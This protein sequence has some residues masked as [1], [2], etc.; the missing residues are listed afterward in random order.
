MSDAGGFSAGAGVPKEEEFSEVAAGSTR[1]E[2]ASGD[3]CGP[4]LSLPYLPPIPLPLF[5]L[6]S[7]SGCIHAKGGGGNV[8]WKDIFFFPLP[9]YSL[10][11]PSIL[12]AFAVKA[13]P[14]G[15]TR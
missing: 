7:L 12:A 1:G 10:T 5:A 3:S 15:D 9:H 8:G 13:P 6:V 2:V 4:S 14:Q 11:A